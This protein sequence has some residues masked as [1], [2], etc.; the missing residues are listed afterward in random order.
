M[1]PSADPVIQAVSLIPPGTALDIACGSGRH[2][3][4]LQ[5]HGWHV[6]ALDRN[7]EAVAQ[8]RARYPSIDARMVDLEREPFSPPETSY[9]LILC[10]LYF[11]RNLYPAIRKAIRPGGIAA[12]SALLQGRFAANPSDLQQSFVGWTVLHRFQNQRACELIVQ[13]P[14]LWFDKSCP[15]Y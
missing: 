14:G 12:L 7:A 10:W 1:T 6:T 2:A 5:Q 15:K 3:I 8:I 11:Q 13:R 9:D 4:W